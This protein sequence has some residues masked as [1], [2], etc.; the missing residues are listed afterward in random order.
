MGEGGECRKGKGRYESTRC[1]A[2]HSSQSAAEDETS[3][4]IGEFIE[5]FM[6]A[7]IFIS[8]PKRLMKEKRRRRE[9]EGKCN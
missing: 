3:I 1:H 9:K 4:R 7:H 2:A 8:S 6:T 5:Y